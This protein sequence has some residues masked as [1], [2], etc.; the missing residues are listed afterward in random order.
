VELSGESSGSHYVDLLTKEQVRA[1]VQAGRVEAV[2][3]SHAAS[4]DQRWAL[5]VKKAILSAF[6]LPIKSLESTD[7]I[8]VHE[9]GNLSDG[10]DAPVA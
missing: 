3:A 6:Q 10:C 7:V 1:S 4:P 9:V 5:N 2:C 8:T